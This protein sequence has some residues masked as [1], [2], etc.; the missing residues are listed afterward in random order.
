[1]SP[2]RKEKKTPLRFEG[3]RYADFEKCLKDRN[4]KG[5]NRKEKEERSPREILESYP[6]VFGSCGAQSCGR[7]TDR[8]KRR[9]ASEN[10]KDREAIGYR[11]NPRDGTQ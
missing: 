11:P 5:G 4:M 6:L 7:A 2:C 9:S 8:K 3:A 10:S 1:M